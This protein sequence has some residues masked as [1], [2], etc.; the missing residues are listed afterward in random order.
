MYDKMLIVFHNLA[1]LFQVP[2][3]IFVAEYVDLPGGT[4]HVVSLH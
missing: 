1:G 4:Q 3:S 2:G